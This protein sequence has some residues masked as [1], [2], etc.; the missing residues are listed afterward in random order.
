MYRTWSEGRQG[1]T[2]GKTLRDLRSPDPGAAH[3]GRGEKGTEEKVKGVER[4]FKMIFLSICLIIASVINIVIA[5]F[6]CYRSRYSQVTQHELNVFNNDIIANRSDIRKL[7]D[8]LNTL[9]ESRKK[10]LL[11]DEVARREFEQLQRKMSFGF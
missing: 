6:V 1:R 2:L 3:A 10:E 7:I 9:V 8:V 5:V 11:Q 4:R